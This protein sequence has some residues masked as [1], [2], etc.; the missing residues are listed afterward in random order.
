MI[1]SWRS[2]NPTLFSNDCTLQ[3]VHLLPIHHPTQLGSQHGHLLSLVYHTSS[4]S[5]SSFR[6]EHKYHIFC[7]VLQVEA[8]VRFWVS[9]ANHN[10][11]S[12]LATDPCKIL[13]N[14]LSSCKTILIGNV[15]F[16][17]KNYTRAKNV[18]AA[19]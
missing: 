4:S 17:D 16:S 5:V 9:S 1:Y 13:L 14:V 15:K 6:L 11:K 2:S 8:S 7:Y 3:T 19:F 10:L 12:A 18:S